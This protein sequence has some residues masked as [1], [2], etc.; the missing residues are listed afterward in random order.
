MS[1]AALRVVRSHIPRTSTGGLLM[2]TRLLG[3]TSRF[4]TIQTKKPDNWSFYVIAGALIPVTITGNQPV[5][6]FMETQKGS[7]ES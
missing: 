6:S 3:K 1:Y 2:T 7:L 4:P 5:L